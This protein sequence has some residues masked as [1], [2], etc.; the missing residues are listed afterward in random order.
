MLAGYK[1]LTEV[2]LGTVPALNLVRATVGDWVYLVGLLEGCLLGCE[3]GL[4]S[5]FLLGCE[6]GLDTG[7]RLGCEEGLEW[8]R[9]DGCEE[10]R[11][12][13]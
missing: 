4:E 6:D 5:G 7:W 13:G 3:E 11:L 9:A 8:G 2:L 12:L 10:G 1:T